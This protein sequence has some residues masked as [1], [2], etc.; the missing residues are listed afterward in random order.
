MGPESSSTTTPGPN[1]IY[2]QTAGPSTVSGQTPV[3]QPGYHCM[4]GWTSLMG[5]HTPAFNGDDLE[6]M[7]ELRNTYEFCDDNQ[8]VA[9][10]CTDIITEKTPEEMGEVVTCDKRRGLV[11]YGK[12]QKDGKCS[13]Y[14]VQFYCDCRP[15]NKQ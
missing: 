14:V 6:I 5:I 15:G 4:Q 13:D 3:T 7:Q 9:I 2:N 11:C 1:T 10:R 12:D 8:I